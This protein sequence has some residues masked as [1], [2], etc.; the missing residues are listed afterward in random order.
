MEEEKNYSSWIRK[1]IKFKERSQ[2]HTN[3]QR[4]LLSSSIELAN[5]DY[6][7]YILSG[8][9]LVRFIFISFEDC[10]VNGCHFKKSVENKRIKNSEY[11]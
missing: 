5:S 7:S 11:D 3:H 4:W 8:E 2:W 1:H 6:I 10:Q 9:R